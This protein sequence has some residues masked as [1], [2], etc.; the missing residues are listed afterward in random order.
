M[1]I[2]SEAHEHF[3]QGDRV[4]APAANPNRSGKLGWFGLAL[5]IGAIIVAVAVATGSLY[6]FEETT[7]AVSHVGDHAQTLNMGHLL[8]TEWD[9]TPLSS[10]FSEEIKDGASMLEVHNDGKTV[11]R[12][13]IWR[14][15]AVQ[16]DQVVGGS[17]IAETD[18]IRPGEF[19]TLEVDLEHGT[20][21]LICSVRGHVGRGMSATFE[22]Q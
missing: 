22:L 15:G 21:V 7:A 20:Y 11:H 18:Y 3:S 12:L 1:A 16:G 13:A 19:T 4:P 10:V 5:M 6:D 2:T 8:L 9:V 14:G 17:L